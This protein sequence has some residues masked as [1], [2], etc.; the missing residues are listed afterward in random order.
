MTAY[1]DALKAMYYLL[2][3]TGV[4]FW[5]DWID[6]DL[7]HWETSKS[8]KHHLSAYGGMGSFNDVVICRMNNHKVTR[9]Q[10]FWVNPLFADLKS[11]CYYFAKNIG[12]PNSVA[13]LEREMGS[14][15]FS[16]Q[17]WRCLKCCYGEVSPSDIES[18]IASHLVRRGIL[19]ALNESNLEN[20][21]KDVLD[22]KLAEADDERLQVKQAVM[23]SSIEIVDRGE[24]GCVR[25]QNVKATIRLYIAG[26]NLVCLQSVLSQLLIIYRFDDNAPSNKSMDVRRKQLLSYQTGL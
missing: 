12:L 3:R 21:V 16:L 5:R 7:R 1:E 23:R 10:E 11:I 8:V 19:Q 20:F 2:E 17:G 18:Y 4:R 6:E 13:S 24:A 15:G 9:Q 25:V 22:L 26:K 14:I